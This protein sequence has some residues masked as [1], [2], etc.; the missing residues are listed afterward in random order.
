MEALICSI[1][2][3]TPPSNLP[4]QILEAFFF[5]FDADICYPVS[6]TNSPVPNWQR[7]HV[8]IATL[9]LLGLGYTGFARATPLHTLEKLD[10]PSPNTKIESSAGSTTS[11]A[12]Y[13]PMPLLVN[14]WASWC[15][16]CIHELPALEVLDNALAKRGMGVLLIGVDRKGREFGEAFLNDRGVSIRQRAYDAKGDLARALTVRVMPT[17]FLVSGTGQLIGKVEG[18]LEWD[19]PT[20]INVV[21][22]LLQQVRP[23]ADKV[24]FSG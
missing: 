24:N 10:L 18:E 2:E 21:Q 7:R 6:M 13:R 20:I 23:S 11:L 16:P 4:P 15:P 8:L 9:S 14:F 17:S 5:F 3:D 1:T 22:R 12:E 19:N